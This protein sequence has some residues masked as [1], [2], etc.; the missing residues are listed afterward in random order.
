M[1][2]YCAKANLSCYN[3]FITELKKHGMAANSIV[4]NVNWSM[5]VPVLNDGSAGVAE[6]S[7]LPG[8]YVK[9]RAESNILAILSNCPQMHNPCN[10]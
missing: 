6:S 1:L 5:S 8:N 3:N 4:P 9:L 2:R 10:G 7:S